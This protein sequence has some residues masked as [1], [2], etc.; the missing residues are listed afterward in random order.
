VFEGDSRG[1][2]DIK[3]TDFGLSK[4]IV[5]DVVGDSD[6]VSLTLSLTLVSP[7]LFR[8]P[9]LDADTDPDFY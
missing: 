6:K 2:F 4:P 7:T 5:G 8:I 9:N 3:I 1:L